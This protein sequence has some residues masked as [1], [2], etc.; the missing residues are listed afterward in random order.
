M[1]LTDQS[2]RPLT[3][4]FPPKR[5]VSLVPSQTELLYDLGLEE[6]VVGITKFCVHPETWFRQKKKVGG[7][8]RLHLNIIRELHPDLI[9]ANKEENEKEQLEALMKDYPVWISDIDTLEDALAMIR[10][11]GDITNR[12]EQADRIA[13]NIGFRFQQLRDYHQTSVTSSQKLRAAYFIWKNPWMA[14]GKDTFIHDML[15]RC[16][17]EN[18]FGH[19]SRYPQI[20]LDQLASAHCQVVLLSSEP[21]PFK[22]KHAEEIHI[23]FPEIKIIFVD[24]EMFSWYGSRLLQTPEYFKRISGSWI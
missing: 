21:F 5:I 16:G 13:H 4:S 8:K 3:L 1:D 23:K 15:P 11:V 22:E 24:G 14:A 7:T 2:G 12:K 17:L 18:C 20:A 9:I 19:L 6:E 10:S